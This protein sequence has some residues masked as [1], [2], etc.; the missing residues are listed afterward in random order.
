MNEALIHKIHHD[1]PKIREKQ[2]AETLKMLDEGDTVPFIARYRKSGRKIWTK[3]K[4]EIFKTPLTGFKPLIN[5]KKK[6]SR[7]LMNSRR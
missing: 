3:L 7:L 2:I 5:V 4:S 1:L 6:S